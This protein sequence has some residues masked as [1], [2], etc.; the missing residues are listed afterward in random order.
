MLGVKFPLFSVFR[1]EENVTVIEY[2]N[3]I[4]GNASMGEEDPIILAKSHIMYKIGKHIH[5]RF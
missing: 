2:D 5:Y 3:F 1:M 4:N